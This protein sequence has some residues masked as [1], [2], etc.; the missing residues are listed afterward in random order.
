MKAV[1]DKS[2]SLLEKIYRSLWIPFTRIKYFVFFIFPATCLNAC[3]YIYFFL[4]F[5]ASKKDAHVVPLMGFR[6]NSYFPHKTTWRNTVSAAQYVFFFFT[7]INHSLSSR[8]KV[9]AFL[10]FLTFTFCS[11]SFCYQ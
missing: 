2:H 9:I 4:L 1:N 8:K 11:S 6:H 7:L 3:F 10:S 5:N